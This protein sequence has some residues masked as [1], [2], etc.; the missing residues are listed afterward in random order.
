MKLRGT[1]RVSH[2]T[3]LDKWFEKN[4]SGLCFQ[5]MRSLGRQTIWQQ[6]AW[7]KTTGR[8]SQQCDIECMH[9][10]FLFVYIGSGVQVQPELTL[11]NQL[12]LRIERRRRETVNN[13]NVELCSTFSMDTTLRNTGVEALGSSLAGPSA[14]AN[15]RWYMI[16]Y[17]CGYV[18]L[19]EKGERTSVY[20]S[21]NRAHA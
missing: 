9:M 4:F 18:S 13:N 17:L 15:F 11:F 20:P 6:T 1:W 2:V 21:I 7:W 8:R 16:L 14:R 10:S 19:S 3:L 5:P 12:M